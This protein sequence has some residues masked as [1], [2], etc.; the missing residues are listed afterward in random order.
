M[1]P[2]HR[3][4][5]LIELAKIARDLEDEILL[6]A[7]RRLIRADAKGAFNREGLRE[8]KEIAMIAAES[9]L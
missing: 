5:I 6:G 2:T 4:E 3:Y 9:F 8:D 7:V 1:I